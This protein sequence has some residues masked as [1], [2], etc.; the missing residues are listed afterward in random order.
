[1]CPPPTHTVPKLKW[2]NSRLLDMADKVLQRADE[3]IDLTIVIEVHSDE[4]D[5]SICLSESS[6][7]SDVYQDYHPDKWEDAV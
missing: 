2:M 5:D 4:E 3:S 6:S 7:S 1:M